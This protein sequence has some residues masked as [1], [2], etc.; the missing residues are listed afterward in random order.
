MLRRE[1]KYKPVVTG[2][3]VSVPYNAQTGQTEGNDQDNK[4]DM[5]AGMSW[6]RI[7]AAAQEEAPQPLN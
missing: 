4:V 5:A 7:G 1:A 6:L 3:Q 2:K